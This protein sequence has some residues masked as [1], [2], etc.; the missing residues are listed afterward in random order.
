MTSGTPLGVIV[1]TFGVRRVAMAKYRLH[2][3]L[4]P[5]PLSGVG[6]RK[7][8][9]MAWIYLGL[10]ILF[11]VAGTTS[12]KMSQGFTQLGPSL[13]IFPAY[14]ISLALLTVAVKTVPISVAYAVWAAVGTALIAAIGILWFREPATP[15][16]LVFIGIIVIGVVGL[17]LSDSA[18]RAG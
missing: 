10:A 3:Y 15:A 6:A 14:G 5:A 2:R 17:H 9:A 1:T 7:G 13:V 16:K 4:R 8:T 11:E 12:L 18:A